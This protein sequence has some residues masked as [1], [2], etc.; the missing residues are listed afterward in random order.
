MLPICGLSLLLTACMAIEPAHPPDDAP[1]LS[2]KTLMARV[3][4]PQADRFWA[5]SGTIT[6]EQGSIDR[7]PTD[8]EGWE[9]TANAAAILVESSRM[10]A[11][12]H[13]R[14]D[15]RDWLRFASQLGGAA[16]AGLRAAESRN[17]TAVFDTGG[18]IYLACRGCHMRYLLG[19]STEE[20]L[21]K[22]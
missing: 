22:P 19:Y 1:K 10:L 13:Q 4:D 8:E 21:R 6:T 12:G 2:L 20:A 17:A 11:L 3:V 18:E 5:A 9:D 16:T 7:S 14:P 15:D